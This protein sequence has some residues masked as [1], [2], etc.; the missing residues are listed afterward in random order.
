MKP[1]GIAGELLSRTEEGDVEPCRVSEG[2]RQ[3]LPRP[4]G[5]FLEIRGSFG[6]MKPILSDL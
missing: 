3:C 5:G 4:E 6:F 2:C 1:T